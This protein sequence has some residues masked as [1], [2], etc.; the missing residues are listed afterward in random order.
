MSRNNLNLKKLKT[1]IEN[2]KSINN[3]KE[4]LTEDSTALET[5]YE[6]FKNESFLNSLDTNKIISKMDIES[7]LTLILSQFANDFKASL[8]KKTNQV[9]DESKRNK[10]IFNNVFMTMSIVNSA[11]S[12]SQ[13]FSLIFHE[14]KGTKHI[15]NYL[16]DEPFV[17]NFKKFNSQKSIQF[18][19]NAIQT[20]Y[21]LIKLDFIDKSFW[22]NEKLLDI[23]DTLSTRQLKDQESLLVYISLCVARIASEEDIQRMNSSIVL[24]IDKLV[25]YINLAADNI[26]MSYDSSCF[27]K[28]S[29]IQITNENDDDQQII[30]TEYATSV[31]IVKDSEGDNQWDTEFNIIEL[32]ICLNSI[33]NTSDSLKYQI[34]KQHN[35]GKTLEKII[36]NGNSIEMEYSLKLLWQ[37]AFDRQVAK[38][39]KKNR[40]LIVHLKYLELNHEKGVS[41]SATGII[42]LTN[43]ESKEKR[44]QS[45]TIKSSTSSPFMDSD[46]ENDDLN[47]NKNEINNITS[48]D[49]KI[50]SSSRRWKEDDSDVSE[51]N[52]D[53]LV[54]DIKEA[55]K[56]LKLIK[57]S[58]VDSCFSAIESLY[59]IIK[60]KKFL[61]SPN[62]SS[63]VNEMDIERHLSL[64]LSTF[65]DDLK[66]GMMKEVANNENRDD[67]NINKI[68]T[69]L[70]MTM[71]IL[72]VTTEMSTSFCVKFHQENGTKNIVNYLKDNSFVEK[73]KSFKNLDSQFII[74][75][76]GGIRFLQNLIVTLYKITKIANKTKKVNSC[77]F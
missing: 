51:K 75:T 28:S 43:K 4:Q 35:M 77:F 54:E 9:E 63:L 1:C 42:W 37:L 41:S 46:D 11:S 62:G 25:K 7:I 66:V 17:D 57:I 33:A 67:Y 45:S 70:N 38:E 10:N 20:C 50:R 68:L 61:Y 21:N 47:N 36:F 5:L 40:H 39:I 2:L 16:R 56:T 13:N 76:N 34:F 55:I 12:K 71:A 3:L 19:N 6:I 18:I 49:N 48:N 44:R 59:K 23:F 72:L 29:G 52:E 65:M 22:S 24:T 73:C 32:L 64:I 27:S 58:N 53:E 74:F 30:T 26:S 8:I 14:K 15:L 69:L 31:S 60:K